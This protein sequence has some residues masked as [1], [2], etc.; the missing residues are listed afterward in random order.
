M[1]TDTEVSSAKTEP[2]PRRRSTLTV[3]SNIFGIILIATT[4][5]QWDLV[6]YVTPFL[7]GPLLLCLLGGLLTPIIAS[8]IHLIVN[9]K[10][11]LSRAFQPLLVNLITLLLILFVPLTEIWLDLEFRLNW[12]GYNEVVQMVIEG[13]LEPDDIGLVRLPAEYR[14]LSKGG[15]DIIVDSS[16]GTLSVFF[17]TFR[18][19][20]DN[21]SGFMYRSNDTPP[22]GEYTIGDW[23]QVIRKRPHWYFCVSV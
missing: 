2:K 4:F 6:D 9:L 8:V 3:L 23:R 21:Y 14:H 11:R 17:F 10:Q 15:G 1:E 22:T 13:T 5:W 18:G 19:I 20:L 12:S 16:D 7:V